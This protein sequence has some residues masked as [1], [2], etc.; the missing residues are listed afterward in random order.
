MTIDPKTVKALRN[1]RERLRDV[2]AANHTTASGH[3][4]RAAAAVAAEHATLT[5]KLDAATMALARATSLADIHAIHDEIA[6]HR[7]AIIDAE[8]AHHRAT[9]DSDA[10]AAQLRERTRELRTVERAIETDRRDRNDRAQRGEQRGHD[11]LSGRR[12]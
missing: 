10:T 1:A 4:E 12:R 2:A 7:A 5:A 9:T 3:R 8:H 6:A 11:D